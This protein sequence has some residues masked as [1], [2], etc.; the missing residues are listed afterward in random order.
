M[1]IQDDRREEIFWVELLQYNMV[2]VILLFKEE[3]V[4]KCRLFFSLEITEHKHCYF[5]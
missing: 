1:E 2:Q 3:F 4:L 5:H